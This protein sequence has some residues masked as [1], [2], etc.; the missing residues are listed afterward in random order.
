M[1]A[2][3]GTQIAADLQK[4]VQICAHQR[5]GASASISGQL[6][7]AESVTIPAM[8]KPCPGAKRYV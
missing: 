3:F 6:Q 8:T 4:I 5:C 1:N 2:A 7:F